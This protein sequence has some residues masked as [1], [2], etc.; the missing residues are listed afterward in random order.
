MEENIFAVILTGGK[1]S[2]MGGGIKSLNKFNNK[3][4]FER[5][6]KNIKSQVNT[7]IINS[8]KNDKFFDKYKV[9]IVA[10][11]L[12]GYL[13]PLAGIHTSLKWCKKN[14]LDKNWLVSISSDT[15]FIP[16][17]LVSNLYLMAKSENKDI[18]LSKSNDKIHPVIGIWNTSLYSSL[19]YNLKSGSRKILDWANMHRVGYADFSNPKYDP[20]FNINY[21]KDLKVAEDIENKFI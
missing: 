3:T 15:P 12:K 16:N 2:R 10:D 19:D 7:I 5:V 4:I 8:N 9:A 13:G 1:S 6:F 14:N 17:D 21:K 20:F 11:E 18:I